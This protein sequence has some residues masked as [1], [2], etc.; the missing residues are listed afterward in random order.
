MIKLLEK[1]DVYETW[2]NFSLAFEGLEMRVSLGAGRIN[3]S[4][5]HSVRGHDWWSHWNSLHC[6]RGDFWQSYLSCRGMTHR[7]KL[8]EW[9]R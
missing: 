3:C 5:T 1:R 8:L 9:S 7:F 2:P 6:H 4:G